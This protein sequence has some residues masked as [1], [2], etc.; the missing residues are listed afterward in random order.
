[1]GRAGK[2]HDDSRFPVELSFQPLSRRRAPG[3]RQHD[4][5]LQHVGLLGIVVRHLQPPL[6]KALVHRGDDF[7]IAFQFYAQRI[8][9]SFAREVVFGRAQPAHEDGDVGAADRRPRYGDEVLAIVADNG[10]EGDANPQVV[11]AAGEEEGI[12][13]LPRRGEHLRA[14]G[15][16]FRDHDFSLAGSN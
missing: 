11:K 14:D 10:L 5:S 1:M 7:V 3:V 8:G 6:G 9:H 2:Q 15:N 12:G 4:R 13:V 16:D